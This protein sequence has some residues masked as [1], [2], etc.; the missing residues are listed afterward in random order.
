MGLVQLPEGFKDVLCYAADQLKGSARRIFMAKTVQALGPGGQRQA[1]RDLGWNRGTLRKGRH[2][3]ESGLARASMPLPSAG[4]RKRKTA[5]R[6][7]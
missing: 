5:C 7:C 2:E 3:L 6:I 4:A 1:E